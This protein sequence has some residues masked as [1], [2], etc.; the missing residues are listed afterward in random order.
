MTL[1]Q[2]CKW[3]FLSYII[4]PF[5]IRVKYTSYKEVCVGI[6][7]NKNLLPHQKEKYMQ[8]CFFGQY[9]KV[10]CFKNT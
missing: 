5:T 2:Y 9:V 10:F 1:K 8:Y 6:N 4:R 3:N 7:F